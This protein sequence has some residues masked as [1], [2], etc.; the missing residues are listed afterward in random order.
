LELDI[1]QLHTYTAASF[2]II[3]ALHTIEGRLNLSMMV[4]LFIDRGYT[5]HYSDTVMLHYIDSLAWG[6]GGDV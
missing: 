1:Y 3:P 4:L 5:E 2:K 6:E